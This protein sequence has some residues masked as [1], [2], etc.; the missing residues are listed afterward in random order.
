MK[1]LLL[2]APGVLELADVPEPVAGE[3]PLKGEV[4]HHGWEATKLELPEWLGDKASAQ[5]IAPAE[6][7]VK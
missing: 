6:V 3:P 5:V 4:A 1:A 2:S 7:E